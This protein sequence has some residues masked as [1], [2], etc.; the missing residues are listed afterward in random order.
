VKITSAVTPRYAHHGDTREAR[1][2]IGDPGTIVVEKIP[3]TFVMKANYPNP[4]RQQ[5]TIE[6]G[7]PEREQVT[8]RLYDVLG[9]R[10]ATFVN[11]S[12]EAGQ[13]EHR[14]DT[15]RLSSGVYFYRMRAGDFTKTK[16]MVVVH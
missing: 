5:T 13:Y 6:Y 12:K 7:L 16:R 14:V 11:G 4:A 9:R 2:L 3:D 15:A 1:P 10:V 8:L